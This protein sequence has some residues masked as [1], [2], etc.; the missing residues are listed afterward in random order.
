MIF[1]FTAYYQQ[2]KQ[3]NFFYHQPIISGH[4]WANH[5]KNLLL[6][7]NVRTHID[8]KLIVK[9]RRRIFRNYVVFLFVFSDYRRG[10]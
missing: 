2:K 5:C 10:L 7:E 8:M 9:N 3:I 4:F 6:M 1:N